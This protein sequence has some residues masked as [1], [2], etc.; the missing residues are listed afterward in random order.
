[1]R[2]MRTKWSLFAIACVLIGL[3]PAS[4]AAGHQYPLSGNARFQVGSGLPVPITFGPVPGGRVVAIP[5]AL[6]EQTEGPDPKQLTIPA[7]QLTAPGNPITLPV[8]N[9]NNGIFQVQTAIG[10]SF[11]RQQATFKANG[12][13][14]APTVT[15]C[16]GQSVTPTGN[17]GCLGAGLPGNVINGRIR[18]TK[19]ANQFGGPAQAAF[20]GIAT[21][22]LRLSGIP[23]CTNCV[24]AFVQEMIPPTGAVGAP[25]GFANQQPNPAPSPGRFF[26]S[27]TGNGFI[28]GV[29]PPSGIGPGVANPA[30]NYGG[31][32]TTGRVTVSATSTTQGGT[33]IFTLTGSDNRVSGVGSISLVSGTIVARSLTGPSAGR[34]WLN[35]TLGAPLPDPQVQ[36]PALADW[37]VGVVVLLL[38]YLGMRSTRRASASPARPR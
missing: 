18:Y 37:G 25:F 30:T 2:T 3:R 21:V 1:M 11:P 10:V 29:T 32:W 6:V 5:G 24:V 26:A 19:T 27:V 7:G 20:S 38:T 28:L 8:Y 16:A 35:L 4:A 31:P 34:G 33:E 23:P 14:G 36:V 9:S 12:R 22:A 17:P 15:F 13:T